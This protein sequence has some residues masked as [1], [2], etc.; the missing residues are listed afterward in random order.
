MGIIV[1]KF[2]G[3]SLKSPRGLEFLLSHVKNCIS[4]KN[5]LVIVVSAI[6]R[7]GDPY[8]TDTLINQLEEIGSPVDPKKK[9]LIMSCGE[10]IS[11]TVVSHL[12]D[13]HGLPSEALTGFQAGIRTDSNFNQSSIINIDTSYI[14][15][16]LNENKILV[17]AGFQ[18]MNEYGEITTLG[19]GGS[20]ITAVA[21]GGYIKAD[22][23]HIF[24]DVP[25]VAVVDPKIVTNTEYIKRI[26]YNDM[27]T[28]SS[29]GAKVIH[30][31][32]V[33]MAENFN[34]PLYIRSNFEFSEGTLVAD[35]EETSFHKLI[36]ITSKFEDSYGR[37]SLFFHQPY[38]I[39]LVSHINRFIT[40]NR[41]GLI[42]TFNYDNRIDFVVKKEIQE[43][44]ANKLYDYFFKD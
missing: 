32:A 22:S 28:L 42:R 4:D 38:L 19:R 2:G 23:V 12:L 25:G 13:T 35:Y 5:K 24:T 7:K 3:S 30:P 8:A 41:Q 6:G 37:I 11:A 39:H 14:L 18:G 17:V 1:Q 9:D 20:D 21:L 33:S 40:Q 10:I 26:S 27:Y 15:K 31:T 16:K 34:I 44:F 29:N 43:D 36:G